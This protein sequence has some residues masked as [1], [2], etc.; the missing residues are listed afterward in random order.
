ML[1]HILFVVF[2]IF[3][4]KASDEIQTPIIDIN[5]LYKSCEK[6]R[7]PITCSLLAEYYYNGIGTDKNLS[8]SIQ[9][10]QNSCDYNFGASCYRAALMNYY[11]EGVEKNVDNAIRLLE[12]SC[13]L[14]FTKACDIIKQQ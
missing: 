14:K 8:K 9:L 2:F 10:F 5:Y 4:A 12:R 11:G 3:N 6:D 13:T 1:K 7:G